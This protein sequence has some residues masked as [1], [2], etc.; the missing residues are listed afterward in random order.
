M[1]KPFIAQES[2]HEIPSQVPLLPRVD[3][4]ALLDTLRFPIIWV[5]ED[6]LQAWLPREVDSL[7]LQKLQANP[8][9]LK[10]IPRLDRLGML[11]SPQM[12]WDKLRAKFQTDGYVVVKLLPSGYCSQLYDYFF[13]QPELTE[14]WADM[15]GIKRTSV[16]NSPLMRLIHQSTE[17]MVQYVIGDVK[18]SYSFTSAYEAGTNLPRHTDRPQCVYN[19]SV[20]LGSNPAGVSLAGWPL[21]IEVDGKVNRVELEVGDAVFYSGVKDPHWRDVIPSSLKGV[22][23]TFFHYVPSSFT[24]SLD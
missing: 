10:L 3:Y 15:E 16:N 5:Y 13:R 20:M 9:D 14:R 24:G 11:E 17:L 6:Y 23:G 4:H 12:T 1:I 8:G 21:F 18:T 22:L 2:P 19:A 7:F